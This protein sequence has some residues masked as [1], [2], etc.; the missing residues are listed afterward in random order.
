MIGSLEIYTRM[1][2]KLSPEKR[3]MLV[4]SALSEAYRLDHFITNILD[5]AK[6]EGGLVVVKCEMLDLNSLIEDSITRLGPR[7]KLHT[8]NLN[9]PSEVCRVFCDPTLLSR[10]VGLVID[11]ATKHAGK[12][13]IIDVSFGGKECDF[14]VRVADNGTGIP[15]GREEEIFSKYA[16]IARNDQQNAGTGLGLSIC[17]QM[18]HMVGGSVVAENTPNGGAIFTLRCPA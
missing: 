4:Q 2:D 17:R 1:L 9:M 8:I 16:R 10:A 18:M 15:P 5:M 7:A 3:A 12:N 13:A 6:L 14:F 11:N